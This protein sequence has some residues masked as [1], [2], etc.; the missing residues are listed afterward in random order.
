MPGT[1][2]VGYQWAPSAQ[3]TV[4]TPLGEVDVSRATLG[5]SEAD[6]VAIEFA[7]GLADQAGAR[8]VAVGVGPDV[9]SSGLAVKG[10]A[11]RGPDEVVVVHDATPTTTS[12]AA[13]LAAQA[14]AV[15][16][17]VAIVLG[18]ASNDHGTR[19]VPALV[20]G[21]L[22][23]PLL[24]DVRSISLGEPAV[25]V[26]RFAGG[27]QT[28]Q[29]SGPLVVQVSP[30][31]VKPRVPGMRDILGAAKKPVQVVEAPAQVAT[32][33]ATSLSVAPIR[34]PVRGAR[35]VVADK[36]DESVAQLIDEL[37]QAGVL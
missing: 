23:R 27:A 35:V 17:L 36:P 29:V 6:Q 22:G 1:V 19:M 31:A 34:P 28:V 12:V 18:D 7:R 32:S 21:L 5:L 3:G 14:D 25:A 16:G 30:D 4:V 37:S 10:V 15:D 26:T 24:A 8:L 33:A 13:A 9:V 20:A 2:L 11:S